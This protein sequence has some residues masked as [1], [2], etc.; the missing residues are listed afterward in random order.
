MSV[1]FRGQRVSRGHPK[2]QRELPGAGWVQ[3][4]VFVHLAV[5]VS[6]SA[7]APVAPLQAQGVRCLLCCGT[8]RKRRPQ[9][10][11]ELFHLC[12]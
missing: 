2:Q 4:D 12:A 8:S 10:A 1:R 3:I 7:T 11:E 6:G 9:D 5:D